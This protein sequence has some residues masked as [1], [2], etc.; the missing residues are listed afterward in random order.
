MPFE[1]VLENVLKY[2]KIINIKSYSVNSVITFILEIPLV[3]S[4]IYDYYQLFPVPT[5][6]NLS[7]YFIH[8]PYKPF[9]ALNDISYIYMDNLCINIDSD[10]YICKRHNKFLISEKAPCAVQLINYKSNLFTCQ[11]FEV[12]I[13]KIESTRVQDGKWIITVPEAELAII[14]CPNSKENILF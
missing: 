2:E 5:H 4:E 9:L 3:E 8:L 6:M 14:E 1:P 11:P 7:K 13:N 10:E 12:R